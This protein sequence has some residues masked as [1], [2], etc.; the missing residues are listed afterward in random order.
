MITISPLDKKGIIDKLQQD[1][2]EEALDF[3]S[4]KAPTDGHLV[5]TILL[6]RG[7]AS[8]L[9]L[10]KGKFPQDFIIA[11]RNRLKAQICQLVEIPLNSIQTVTPSSEKEKSVLND[12][13]P[14]YLRKLSILNQHGLSP[15]SQFIVNRLYRLEEKRKRGT[16]PQVEYQLQLK[17][18]AA[19]ITSLSEE[20]SI[21]FP[22]SNKLLEFPEGRAIKGKSL[23]DQRI[24]LE[25]LLTQQQANKKQL[26]P[27]KLKITKLIQNDHL[28]LVTTE[29]YLR[30][31]AKIDREVWEALREVE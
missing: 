15:E 6:L 9:T 22:S 21:S 25:E 17:R 10:D 20:L 19:S 1:R 4:A 11:E 2:L 12:Q 24:Q 13:V 23:A 26:L 30:E 7:R 5:N 29:E 8:M 27:L 14:L 18:I 3:L 16:L 31:S 28:G